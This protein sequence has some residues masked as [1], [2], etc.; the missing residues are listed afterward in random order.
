MRLAEGVRGVFTDRRGGVSAAPYDGRNLGGM[1]GDDPEAVR[2][3]RAATAAELGLAPDRVVYMRQVHGTGV[4]YVTEPFDGDPPPLDAVF[5]DRP[6]LGLGVLVADCAPVLL[7][8]PVAGVVGAAHSGRAGTV[9]GVVPALVAAMAGRGADP[10]RMVAA[11][12]PLACGRCYEVPAAM[13][14][15]VAATMPA[16]RSTTAHG[17]PALDLRAGISAQ[18]AA[19]GVA[20]V[21]H[22]AR[23]TIESPELYSYRR[24]RTTGRFAGYVWLED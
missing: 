5:T 17:T 22:D 15:E 13:C 11:I 21:R 3:N 6:G 19:A 24:E 1:V 12:G 8:D 4:A 7:A 16:A 23:C 18:L 14:D 2:R 9:A 10:G 20:D